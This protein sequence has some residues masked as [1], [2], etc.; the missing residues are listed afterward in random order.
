MRVAIVL[1][2]ALLASCAGGTRIASADR[3]VPTSVASLPDNLHWFRDSAEQ[4]A[5]YLEIYRAATTAA[6]SL[7]S[8]LAPRSWGVIL[9]V[10]ETIL[11]NSEFAKRYVSAGRSFDD[12]AWNAF[13][14]EQRSTLLPGAREFVDTVLDELHG[15][16]VLVTNRG[17]D[18]CAATE[19]NLHAVR[20]R[21]DRILCDRTGDGNKNSRFRAVIAGER[22]VAAPLD[23]LV[24][25]GD[26]IGDFPS[27]TQTAP[28]DLALFGLSYFVLPNPLYGSWTSNPYR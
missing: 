6:R 14:R 21:Y 23:V 27:L 26:N 19:G 10:D 7:S 2:A 11:D 1:V 16:V 12:A 15:Q 24:W 4:R 13:V 18:Q 9:D 22:G 25:V 8:G 5:A 17:E 20:I 28:G 3:A